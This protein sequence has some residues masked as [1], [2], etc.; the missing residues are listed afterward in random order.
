MLSKEILFK[1]LSHI[2]QL[3]QIGIRQTEQ[4]ENIAVFSILSFHD[5]IEMF[6]K[7][8][9]EHK[10]INATKFSFL[11][12]WEKIP[13]L[14]L[15]ESMRSLNARRVNMKH[16]GLLPAKSELEISKVN[17]IDFFNQN[18]IIQF[19]IDFKDV[20]LIE[21]VGYEKVKNYLK[22]SQEALKNG[23]HEESIENVAYSFEELLHSYEKN[24]TFWG[25]SPFS[26]GADM[27]FMSSFSMGASRFDNDS[28]IEKLGEFIDKV[29]D[30]IEDLQRAVKITSFGLDYKEY[31]K[32][33][34]LTPVVTRFIGGKV[35]AQIM[36]KR[37]WTIEN[38]QYCIDF[39][40]KSA[41]SLQEFDFDVESLE[42]DRAKQVT[43]K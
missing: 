8:L 29:K 37:K 23:K 36:G 39:V 5:S 34:I 40:I 32:F 7:L 38:C 4:H 16:K 26:V 14:T 35:N 31:V 2:K 21:L 42:D 10:G 19:G 3:Y 9:T 43:L 6:L 27:T 25:I 1:R 22:K 11:E 13:D 18:T 12:Y 15:K 41:L 28:G 24:K 17:A 33:N 20:S 30:S